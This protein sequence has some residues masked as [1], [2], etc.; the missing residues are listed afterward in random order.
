MVGPHETDRKQNP[1]STDPTPPTA[2]EHLARAENI[3]HE[4]EDILERSTTRGSGAHE[5][6]NRAAAIAQLHVGIA[7][8]MAEI[9]VAEAHVTLADVV[10]AYSIDAADIEDKDHGPAAW[11]PLPT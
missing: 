5:R 7:R 1:M 8:C 2:A 6:F 11:P 3:L 10:T 9:Q 4:L